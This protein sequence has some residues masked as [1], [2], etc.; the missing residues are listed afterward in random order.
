[1]SLAIML[2][3]GVVLVKSKLLKAEDS[4]VLSIVTIYIIMPCVILNAFQVELTS[5]VLSGLLLSFVAA[6]VFHVVVL[7]VNEPVKRLLKLDAVEQTSIIYSNSGSLVIP[8]VTAMLGSEWVIYASGFLVVQM[9]LL[10]SHCKSVICGEKGFDIKKLLTNVNMIFIVISIIFLIFG[11]HFPSVIQDTVS[12]FSSMIGPISMVITGMLIGN[13]DLKSMMKNKRLWLVTLLRLIAVPGLTAIALKIA[14][15]FIHIPNTSEILLITLLATITPS[16]STITQM[17][18]VYDLDAEYA[19]A[20]NV[21][22][23]ILCVITMPVIVMLY[24]L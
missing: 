16:A 23:T 11:V 2:I 21:L 20:I 4:K 6:V 3:L 22:S 17:A 14:S 1:M 7:L 10:W 24:Q 18:Q 5:D 9:I 8:L 15:N 12:S 13:I 19:S